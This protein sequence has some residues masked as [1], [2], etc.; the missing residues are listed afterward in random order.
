MQRYVRYT[1]ADNGQLFILNVNT[2]T[3]GWYKCRTIATHPQYAVQEYG[4][5]VQIA[6]MPQKL[7]PKYLRHLQSKFCVSLGFCLLDMGKMNA[8]SSILPK[9][10][11]DNGNLYF[12]EY[13]SAELLCIAPDGLPPPSVWWESSDGLRLTEPTRSSVAI[14]SFYRMR[15]EDAGSYFCCAE[16]SARKETANANLLITS[17]YSSFSFQ[18]RASRSYLLDATG[19]PRTILTLL[20]PCAR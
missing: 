2:E 14:L 4:T 11:H 20:Q 9:P 3:Q 15:L 1:V 17:N 19:I 10:M 13:S 7:K 5:L 16:N 6:C 12:G 18:L 8:T